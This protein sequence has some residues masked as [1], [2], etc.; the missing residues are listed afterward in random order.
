MR[1]SAPSS[2][3]CSGVAFAERSLETLGRD[4]ERAHEAFRERDQPCR[5][6]IRLERVRAGGDLRVAALGH[7]GELGRELAAPRLHLEQQRLGRL[8]GE[9][10]LAARRVVAEALDGDRGD[11]RR[12]QLLLRDDGKLGLALADDNRERAEP[13]GARPLEEREG[14]VRV[15][16]DERRG[17]LAK[18]CGDSAF[19]PRLDVEERERDALALLGES[20]RGR[21]EPLALRECAVER[22][23]PFLEETRLLGKRLALALDAL[24]EN[25]PRL[26]GGGAKTCEARLGRLAAEHEPLAGAAQAVERLQRLLARACGVGELLLGGGT[27]GEN[28]G[29]P[30]LDALLRSARG[31]AARVDVVEANVERGEIELGDARVEAGDLAAELLGALGRGRLQRERPEPLAHLGFDVASALDLD[32]DTRELQLGAMSPR[33]EAPEP[34]G[35]LD[36]RAALGGTRRKD[37][38]DFPLADDRVH[39]LPEP[40]VGEQLDEIEPPHGRLVDEVLALAAAVETARDRQLRKL[41]GQ[42]AVGVVEEQLHFTEIATTTA[43]TA[44]EEDVVGLLGAQLARAQRAGGPADRVGDVRLAGAVRADDDAD[45]RLEANLDGLRKRLEATQLYRAKMH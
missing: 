16:G 36:E 4:V 10:E 33:L 29:E 20:P 2:C 21:R 35:F 5:A 6:R 42:R 22:A 17:A 37:R 41:H 18:R 31:R 27:L 40:E 26:L 30:C 14:R 45:P 39:P 3:G 13:G 12:E 34:R 28:L 11:R 43:R 1:S 19:H 44:G 32:R 8:A 9:P 23:K 7:L 15:V 24:V 38:L 25:A